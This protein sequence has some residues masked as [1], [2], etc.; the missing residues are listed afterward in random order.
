[1]EDTQQEQVEQ[2]V[3]ETETEQ[4]QETPAETAEQPS[5][6]VAEIQI[7]DNWEQG[8][9]DYI[10]SIQDQAGK[11]AV[12]DKISNLENG[13]NKKYR[14][15][16]EKT[17]L[18]EQ[19]KKA[20]DENR[21]LFDSYSA[22]DKGIDPSMRNSILGQYGSVA[23]YMNALHNMDLMASRD[24]Q[25]FLIN[26]CNNNGITRENLDQFLSGQAYQDVRQTSS[27]EELKAQIMKE[28]EAKQQQQRYVDE[29]RRFASAKNE[30]GEVLHPLLADNSFVADMEA[31]QKAYPDRDLESLYQMTCNIRPDL[32]QREIEDEARKLAEARDVEKAKSAVGVKPRVPT[33]GAKPDKSWQ[34]VLSEQLGSD[35]DY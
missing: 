8:I 20:F 3:V 26:Y 4:E 18:F 27:Q 5:E 2:E 32:R 6:T 28:F 23:G 15:I 35:D 25:Q 31:L 22:F 33:H 1:M 21:A 24:P 34:Q 9:K 16:A 7:P 17:R 11:K 13:Y 30:S 14:D 19:D 12:F 29:V 10:N